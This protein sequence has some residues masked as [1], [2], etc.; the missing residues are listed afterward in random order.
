MLKMYY[1]RALIFLYLFLNEGFTP[2][3]D[4]IIIIHTFHTNL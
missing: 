2:L 4:R 1:Q 3:H